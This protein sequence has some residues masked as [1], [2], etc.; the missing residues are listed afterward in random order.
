MN[1]ELE[2]MMRRLAAKGV[3]SAR[4]R[5]LERDRADRA[6][7]RRKLQR[8]QEARSRKKFLEI[9]KIIIDLEHEKYLDE[10]EA[11]NAL[12]SAEPLNPPT[13]PRNWKQPGDEEDDAYWRQLARSFRTYDM[14]YLSSEEVGDAIRCV[15]LAAP[16][17]T[18]QPM[19][20]EQEFDNGSY[21]E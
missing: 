6:M 19:S 14:H 9:R 7:I 16:T 15:T 12:G 13:P 17:R 8:G 21:S 3:D 4:R 10:K 2:Q 20:P 18:P 5:K 1:S 11:I